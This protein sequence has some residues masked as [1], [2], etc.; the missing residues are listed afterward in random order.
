VLKASRILWAACNPNV[1]ILVV[2]AN[3]LLRDQVV[4]YIHI[5]VCMDMLILNVL[6]DG[7]EEILHLVGCP[8]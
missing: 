3:P 2:L 4:K 1:A 8:A 7:H 5:V 6:P